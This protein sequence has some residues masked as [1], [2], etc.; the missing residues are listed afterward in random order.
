MTQTCYI[1]E[2]PNDKVIDLTGLIDKPFDFKWYDIYLN[3]RKLV[4]KNVE[5][6]SANKI[7]I[8][9]TDSLKG[10]EII[11]NSRDKEYFGYKPVYDI[12]DY[13][14]DVDPEFADNINNSIITDDMLD[15]EEP[16][17]ND[18]ITRVDYIINNLVNDFILANFGMFN[19]DLNQIPKHYVDLYSML[20]KDPLE[21]NPDKYGRMYAPM[22]HYINPNSA[23]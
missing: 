21:L 10:L 20:L 16:T 19:P 1:E 3:G 12:I 9:K 18:I 11:E 5:I 8:L 14:Y 4:K 6:I 22:V 13:L 15:I 7:K 23:K 2:I 17:V